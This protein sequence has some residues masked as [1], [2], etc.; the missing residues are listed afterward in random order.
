LQSH[1]I[2]GNE[3]NLINSERWDDRYE[4][5]NDY[6][7]I[8]KLP[9]AD[10]HCHIGS[11]MSADL[12][13]KTALLVLAEKYCQPKDEIS[14]NKR[15][16]K[17]IEFLFPIVADPHLDETRTSQ[18]LT[19][20]EDTINYKEAFGERDKNRSIFQIIIDVYPL[21]VNMRKPEQV[22]LDPSDNTLESTAR[23]FKNYD[24]SIYFK[25][26][27]ELLKLKV[28]YDEVM[29]FFILLLYV[30]DSKKSNPLDSLHSEIMSIVNLVKIN[31]E[32]KYSEPM[33]AA[34]EYFLSIFKIHLQPYNE[35]L[36][37]LTKTDKLIKFLQSAHSQQRCLN[38][39]QSSLFSYLRGCEYSGAPHLQSRASIFMAIK[40]IVDY[41]NKDNIRYLSLRC[42]INGYSKFKLQTN[43]EAVRSL[44]EAIEH[45]KKYNK[46]VHIDL[47]ISANRAK[48]I[49]EFE[50][51]VDLAIQFKNGIQKNLGF[52]TIKNNYIK[53]ARPKV[54]SFD[55]M[56]LEKG[57]RPSKFKS[58]FL[59]L[60]KNCFP[61]TIHAGEEDD[62][63]AIWEAVYEVH[64][65]RLGHALS[66]RED[67]KLLNIVR[68]RHIAIELCPLSNLLTKGDYVIPEYDDAGTPKEDISHVKKHHNIYPLRQY[69]D[70]N[71]DVTINTD[72]PYVSFSNMTMEYIVA[73]RLI[74][75]LTKWEILRLIKNGFR[76]AAIPKK[77]KRILMNE[78]DDEI[79]E[80]MLVEDL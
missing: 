47:I 23:Y 6:Q 57:N 61:I 73:A 79:Y 39:S 12:L 69:L 55:L 8:K 66:L 7:W 67:D 56:G 54:V 59:P 42:N 33:N 37:K 4:S 29:L 78:I 53:N 60:F 13:P 22:L 10:L 40:D 20:I 75:G 24:D 80:K 1:W 71:L 28:D 2:Y 25:R 32:G 27:K 74:S 65:Q 63:D 45:F 14:T 26:K 76:S 5:T 30:R 9:K 64:S 41:A 16:R 19:E 36:N 15:I 50:N 70:E 43:E 11:C 62:K 38:T 18:L 49:K 58:N 72:N 51:N 46:N 44:L 34:V 31:Y 35:I 21:D 77:E 52:D 17:I 68:E 48:G 3:Y